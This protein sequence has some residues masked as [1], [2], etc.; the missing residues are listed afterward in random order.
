MDDAF[1][2]TLDLCATLGIP[3][4][5]K[6]VRPTTRLTFLGFELDT[7]D[8]TISLPAKKRDAYI[9]DIASLLEKRSTKKK[10]L[11]SLLGKLQFA[12][13][14]IPIG[15]AFLRSLINKCSRAFYDSS[16]VSLSKE[17]RLNLQW[18]I[19][20]LSSW[21]GVTLM[22]FCDWEPLFDFQISSDAAVSE[23]F[24]IVNGNEWCRGTWPEGPRLNIAILEMIPLV[25]SALIWGD[26]WSGKSI[27]FYTDSMAVHFSA[28][29]LL[30]KEPHLA[31]L[32]REL[33]IISIEKDFRFRTEHL[34]GVENT[35][36]DLLSRAKVSAFLSDHPSANPNPVDFDLNAH[37][38]RLLNL[39]L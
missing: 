27:I 8:L 13:T 18:W 1:Q 3:L 31:A 6:T 25:V 26:Q 24:G 16:F 7:V 35:R 14:V 20:L 22:H 19:R 30:P 5:D 11:Q 23:G 2:S 17:E 33:A 37:I 36:A 32:I 39:S 28:Q 15:R 38:T 10:P 29:S 12:A 9:E 34:P 4:A 21:N